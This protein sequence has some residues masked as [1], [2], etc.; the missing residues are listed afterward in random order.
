MISFKSKITVKLL[1]YFFLN[2]EAEHYI[3]ELAKI[4][5]V[6]PKNLHRKLEELEKEGLLISDYKGQERYFS[7][8]N[9]SPLLEHY[10]QIFLT[11]FG[12]EH[13]LKEIVRVTPG[14]TKAYIFGSY[15]SNK[16]DSTSDIDLLVVGNHSVL[17][18]QKRINILQKEIGREI[19]SINISEQE[20]KQK[21]KKDQFYKNIFSGDLIELL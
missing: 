11:T 10:R 3:N 2:Q 15:A 7:L 12:L 21:M 18:L 6:D 5:S 17:D 8:N 20:L 1:D 13:K 4:L 9:E 19:N 14:I 16:F